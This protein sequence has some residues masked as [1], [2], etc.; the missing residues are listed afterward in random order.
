M[1]NN[2][3]ELVA[4]LPTPT[5]AAPDG[6]QFVEHTGL[7]AV[8]R[9]ERA[10]TLRLME[11]R[12]TRLQKAARHQ[13]TL[14]ALM[15]FGTVL[16]VQQGTYMT[17]EDGQDMLA[18][19]EPVLQGALQRMAGL[20]QFQVSVAWDQAG[21]LSHFRDQP[22]LAPLFA[23]KS[24]RSDMLEVAIQALAGRLADDMSEK[25]AA[26]AV[27]QLALPLEAT[28]IFNTAILLRQEDEMRLDAVVESID[29]IWSEGF[30]IKQIGPA[31]GS[32]F[33]TVMSRK[34][35][36]TEIKAAIKCLGLEGDISPA[37]VHARRQQLLR[38]PD[39]GTS[40]AEIK[41]AATL[42]EAVSRVQAD[43]TEFRLC[44]VWSESEA[45]PSVVEP[46]VAAQ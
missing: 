43:L 36:N 19:N 1:S 39:A 37:L 41:T 20:V 34:V 21:V 10:P 35:T 9:T 14:E 44:T 30:Q 33:G 16:P 25:L 2:Q 31:P 17:L 24:V 12:K 42:L 46:M 40:V 32:S 13:K 3:H 45:S 23:G 5:V 11:G 27:D 22:E 38:A 6:L 26:V 15:A 8:F 4:V 7:S 18:A 28:T 29:A